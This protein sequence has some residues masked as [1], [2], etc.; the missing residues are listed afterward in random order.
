ML[1]MAKQIISAWFG[2]KEKRKLLNP[3]KVAWTNSKQNLNVDIIQESSNILVTEYI[4]K[5]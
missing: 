4:L 1:F 5:I 2:Y 3:K